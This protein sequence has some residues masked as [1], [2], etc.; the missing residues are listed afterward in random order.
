MAKSVVTENIPKQTEFERDQHKVGDKAKRKHFGCFRVHIQFPGSVSHFAWRYKP[1]TSTCNTLKLCDTS[2][3]GSLFSHVYYSTT[4]TISPYCAGQSCTIMAN[5]PVFQ[6]NEGEWTSVR[7][8]EIL[9]VRIPAYFTTDPQFLYDFITNFQT[10]P[11]DVFSSAI[12]NQVLT[13]LFK[14]VAKWQ[15]MWRTSAYRTFS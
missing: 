11:D 10:K 4:S 3:S 2:I 7:T 14:V 12:P 5:F 13:H 8:V 6:E 15:I 1:I 9:G